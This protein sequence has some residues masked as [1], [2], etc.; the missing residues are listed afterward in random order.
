MLPCRWCYPCKAGAFVRLSWQ[1]KS[2]MA[3]I[4]WARFLEHDHASRTR[5]DTRGRHGWLKRSIWLVWRAH[6]LIARCGAAGMTPS[7]PT[8][9]SGSNLPC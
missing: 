7:D 3:P 1:L 5:R 2:L 4:G 8:Y 9:G 6:G